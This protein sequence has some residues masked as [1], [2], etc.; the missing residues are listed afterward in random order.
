MVT[1]RLELVAA[2]DALISGVTRSG[3][4]N[5]RGEGGPDDHGHGQVE[6]VPPQQELLE[7]PITARSVGDPPVRSATEARVAREWSWV[8]PGHS[9]NRHAA[10]PRA[11]HAEPP[12][13]PGPAPRS[14]A[15]SPASSVGLAVPARRGDV[16]P[17]ST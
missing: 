4:L 2:E 6:Q 5:H 13:P 1:C 15:A 7:L 17:A 14:G 10:G 11:I 8:D 12:Q 3:D 16:V 9:V